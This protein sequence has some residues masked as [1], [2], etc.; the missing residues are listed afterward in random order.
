M[1]DGT[2]YAK[3]NDEQQK[4]LIP[5]GRVL[6]KGEVRDINGNHIGNIMPNSEAVDKKGM[7]I[8]SSI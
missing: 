6:I 2:V 8:G 1:P 5:I 7:V 3:N 4:K